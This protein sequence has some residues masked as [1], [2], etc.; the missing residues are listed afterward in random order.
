MFVILKH[1]STSTPTFSQAQIGAREVAGW[2]GPCSRCDARKLASTTQ[3]TYFDA[4]AG[5]L[6]LYRIR[7]TLRSFGHKGRVLQRAA[8]WPSHEHNWCVNAT[9]ARGCRLPNSYSWF[10]V[11]ELGGVTVESYSEACTHVVGT[12]QMQECCKAAKRAGKHVVNIDWASEC[13]KKGVLL[14]TDLVVRHFQLSSALTLSPRWPPSPPPPP[15]PVLGLPPQSTAHCFTPLRSLLSKRHP[16]TP[17]A[18]GVPD[19]SRA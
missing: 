4:D 15:P 19:A 12:H 6:L 14:P 8:R 5:L 3:D 1:N 18:A 17:S 16:S 2:Q 9:A 10:F 7:G 11:G 13:Q